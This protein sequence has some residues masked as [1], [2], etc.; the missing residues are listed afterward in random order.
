[1]FLFPKHSSTPLVNISSLSG[2][3]HPVLRK[4]NLVEM[5]NYEV[6]VENSLLANGYSWCDSWNHHECTSDTLGLDVTFCRKKNPVTKGGN[7]KGLKS[8]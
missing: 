1:M 5:N 4:N 3:T 2:I 8:R 6:F 7:H